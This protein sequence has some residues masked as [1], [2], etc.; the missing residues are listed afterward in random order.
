MGL[1]CGEK[2]NAYIC[3]RDA[4]HEGF[5]STVPE[6]KLKTWAGCH[7]GEFGVPVFKALPPRTFGPEP[8][9]AVRCQCA[10]CDHSIVGYVSSVREM[11]T[12]WC[13]PCA[14]VEWQ[15]SLQKRTN[16]NT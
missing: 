14:E 6:D 2:K 11:P 13:E 8:A 16:E 4:G 7:W 9:Q 1:T 10:G 5:H 3:A 12:M 15:K